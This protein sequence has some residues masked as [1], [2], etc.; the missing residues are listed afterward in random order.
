MF[1][2]GVAGRISFSSGAAGDKVVEAGIG[3]SVVSGSGPCG[4]SSKG[5]SEGVEEVSVG[6]DGASVVV[7]IGEAVVVG[8]PVGLSEKLFGPDDGKAD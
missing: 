7:P 8:D 5:L 2:P 4:K 1:S 6:P 3:A